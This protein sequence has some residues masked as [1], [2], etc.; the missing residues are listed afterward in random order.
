MK[1]ILLWHST[2]GHLHVTGNDESH[3]SAT[4]TSW[5]VGC[6]DWAKSLRSLLNILAFM[7]FIIVPGRGG[8]T[9]SPWLPGCG[10]PRVLIVLG[11]FPVSVPSPRSSFLYP[12]VGSMLTG[13]EICS[14]PFLSLPNHLFQK[15]PERLF[16]SFWPRPPIS[17]QNCQR[18]VLHTAR[19]SFLELEA[20]CFTRQNQLKPCSSLGHFI[21]TGC[22]RNSQVLPSF[23]GL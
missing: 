5:A 10:G 8:S 23:R 19:F 12:V 9:E 4:H 6:H 14:F 20:R 3:S 11:N 7:D 22:K 1:F 15:Q 13:V 21:L 17:S 18:V 16:C 2:V